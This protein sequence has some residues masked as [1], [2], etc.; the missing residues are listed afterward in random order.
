ML[1]RD[2]RIRNLIDRV[3]IPELETAKVALSFSRISKNDANAARL[4]YGAKLYANSVYSLQQSVE[5]SMKALGLLTGTLHN[6]ADELVGEVRHRA[7]KS[8]LIHIDSFVAITERV[9]EGL[10]QTSLRDAMPIDSLKNTWG[11]ADPAIHKFATSGNPSAASIEAEK[12]EIMNLSESEMWLPSLNLDTTNKWI[13]VAL[14]NLNSKP[15]IGPKT[16]SAVRLLGDI[17]TKAGLFTPQDAMKMTFSDSLSKAI[18]HIWLSMLTDWHEE[19][20]R[21]PPIRS[22]DFWT[23]DAY[24]P[25]KP[26]VKS[27]PNLITKAS[28]LAD[29]ID[30]AAQVR[31]ELGNN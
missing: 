4:T 22:R 24:M 30:R 7:M 26:L 31:V 2:P 3:P 1:S 5:K 9:K 19:A 23:S 17:F 16:T 28:S 21:Y 14:A 27:L 8:V 25:D 11:K 6:D 18:P 13:Q 29:A 15:L 10:A 12:R 20:T